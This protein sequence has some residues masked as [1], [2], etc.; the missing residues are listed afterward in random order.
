M[1]HGNSPRPVRRRLPSTTARK[2]TSKR[3]WI[4]SLYQTLTQ[5]SNPRVAIIGVGNEMRGDDAAGIAVVEALRPT[6]H[7]QLLILNAGTAPENFTGVLRQF[8]PDLVLLID[9]VQMNEPPGTIRLLDTHDLESCS[10]TTHSLSLHLFV[11]YLE[12]ELKC[13]FKLLGIQVGQDTLG[14]ELSPQV[15]QRVREIVQ[16]LQ[17]LYCQPVFRSYSVHP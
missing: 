7:E 17:T 13:K 4:E 6:S 14:A 2:Q 5:T 10:G 11:S 3:S 9:A 1:K 12:T 15:R 16:T 8:A